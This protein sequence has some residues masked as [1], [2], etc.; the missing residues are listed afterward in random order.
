MLDSLFLYRYLYW[1]FF[2]VTSAL[3]HDARNDPWIGLKMASHGNW[4]WPDGRSARYKNWHNVDTDIPRGSC[5]FM[6]RHNHEWVNYFHCTVKR[7][8][9][10][11][12]GAHFDVEID[13]INA[14]N[15]EGKTQKRHW[16][17]SNLWTSAV[18]RVE[19]YSW[20]D[21]TKSGLHGNQFAHK[22]PK[23]QTIEW[24]HGGE[25]QESVRTRKVVRMQINR[26]A[27]LIR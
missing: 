26:G 8:F 19:N 16:I 10:C 27:L 15:N 9:I 17:Y 7:P 20:L 22:R 25:L 21:T 12:M 1:W 5:A 3:S 11:E 2:F 23:Q 6:F 18:T 4:I 24:T 14:A 13:K